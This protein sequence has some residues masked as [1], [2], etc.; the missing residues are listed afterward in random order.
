MAPHHCQG[1]WFGARSRYAWVPVQGWPAGRGPARR[2]TSR[3]ARGRWW[4]PGRPPWWRAPRGS[5]PAPPHTPPPRCQYRPHPSSAPRTWRW[6]T[7]PRHPGAQ[8]CRSSES[9]TWR[10]PALTWSSPRP[11]G[12]RDPPNRRTSRPTPPNHR[13]RPQLGEDNVNRKTLEN[14]TRLT[15]N[16]GLKKRRQYEEHLC[17]QTWP[18]HGWRAAN[19]ILYKTIQ[20][21]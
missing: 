10:R 1:H 20:H 9:W 8:G 6:G 14:Q 12:R 11:A 21:C 16:R 7:R 15:A 13:P 19:A 2:R 18:S 5:R 3:R 4:S 17:E